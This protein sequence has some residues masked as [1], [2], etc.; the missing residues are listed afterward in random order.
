M[1]KTNPVQRVHP[2]TA[3]GVT[4]KAAQTMAV[5]YRGEFMRK[6]AIWIIIA[7]MSVAVPGVVWLQWDLIGI[8]VRV[9][10]ERFDKNV[11]DALNEV[12][13]QLE[14]DESRTEFFSNLNING[15]ITSYIQK[16]RL[17][18]QNISP[19]EFFSEIIKNPE[20]YAL[21]GLMVGNKP[22]EERIKPRLLELTLLQA[23]Q[24]RGIDPR[25]QKFVYR[26]GIYSRAKKNFV[27][28]NGNYV[29]SDNSSQQNSLQGV[30]SKNLY[31]PD[32]SVSI[33]PHEKPSSGEL[34]VFFPNRT[35]ILWSSLWQNLIGSI[36][37]S[38]TI[39]ICFGYTVYIIYRQKQLS[40]MKTDF[41]NNMTHEFKTPIATISLATD[42]ITNPSIL[43]NPEKVKRFAHIIKQENNRMN[44][45]VEKVLQMALID[46]QDFSLKIAPV[47]LHEII[48]AA[49]EHINL[50]V[51]KKGGMATIELKAERPVV[52]G[53]LTHISSIIHNLL[54]NANKYSPEKPE[55]TVSTQ[56]T[57]HGVEVEVKD[58]GIGMN[59]AAL[60]HIFDKFYR[61]STGN[62]HD[63][64]GFGLGLSYVKAMMDAHQGRIDVKSEPGKGSS[65][66]L[67]F[68]F[69]HARD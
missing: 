62:L 66:I 38:I 45:Q 16:E 47:N 46:K 63:V 4:H 12:A 19:G 64:K 34:R 67:Y 15:F 1:S 49:V 14:A 26:Y 10:E 55:I 6:N 32:Y 7:L 25:K 56:N 39:V 18:D 2:R 13:K 37:F 28:I 24:N 9:N 69:R 57:P 23:F 61:V 58:A 54:D 65:F 5:H 21:Y 29:V 68:P 43:G 3:P 42:S 50:Q 51:E 60:K 48:A 33:F 22:I 27:I 17:L 30:R 11:Y 20:L 40:A 31:N 44:N 53:D 35:N 59:K 8:S 52:E 36:F 41:I